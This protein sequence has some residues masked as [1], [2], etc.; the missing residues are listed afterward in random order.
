MVIMSAFDSGNM[1]RVLFAHQGVQ[2]PLAVGSQVDIFHQKTVHRD[3]I[4]LT[5]FCTLTCFFGWLVMPQGSS[6]APGCFVKVINDLIQGLANVAAYLARWVRE[7][8]LPL[9]GL[10]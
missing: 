3:A 2:V 9:E 1:E 7:F 4:P 6:A 10:L 5:A 8:S